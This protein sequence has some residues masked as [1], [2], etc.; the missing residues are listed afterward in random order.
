MKLLGK[1][2]KAA[3]ALFVLAAAITLKVL[4]QNQGF[5]DFY[6]LVSPG[7][8]GGLAGSTG[9]YDTPPCQLVTCS[10]DW[11][12]PSGSTYLLCNASPYTASCSISYGTCLIDPICW[13]YVFSSSVGSFPCHN[14]STLSCNG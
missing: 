9:C 1:N 8:C 10:P 11:S 14:A 7:T 2:K 6:D 3:I 5:C 13:K 12:C 4:S